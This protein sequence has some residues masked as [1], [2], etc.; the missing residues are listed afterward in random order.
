MQLE[1]PRLSG[2]ARIDAE[3]TREV[4]CGEFLVF[5]GFLSR[6]LWGYELLQDSRCSYRE[7]AVRLFRTSRELLS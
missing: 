6:W 7:A 3:R 1:V 2:R 4:V 5:P